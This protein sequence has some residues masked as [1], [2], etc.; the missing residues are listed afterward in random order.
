MVRGR[1]RGLS[2]DLTAINPILLCMLKCSIIKLLFICCL[3]YSH[4]HGNMAV[5]AAK[6]G[7]FFENF[8]NPV[9]LDPGS[10]VG[11]VT[12]AVTNVYL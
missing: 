6:Y 4:I 2:P 7:K 10:D 8:D 1:N 5:L 12:L 3:F 9:N 11:F